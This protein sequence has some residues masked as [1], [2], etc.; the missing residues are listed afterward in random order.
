MTDSTLTTEE[1]R[2][3]KS[4]ISLRDVFTEPTPPSAAAQPSRAAPKSRPAVSMPIPSVPS[5][6]EVNPF[7]IA[8]FPGVS[9]GPASSR[10]RV[11]AAAEMTVPTA[12]ALAELSES[13]GKEVAAQQ[14]LE[15]AVHYIQVCSHNT[16]L[17]SSF[18]W[19]S[20]QCGLRGV[21]PW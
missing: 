13:L 1:K 8:A 9:P 16:S 7:D 20:L 18:V 6:S 14:S 21:P 19:F 5:I 4:P 11:Q 3:Q 2:Q 10:A 17:C 12:S 15:E